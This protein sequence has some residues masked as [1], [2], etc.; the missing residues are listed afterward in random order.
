VYVDPAVAAEALLTNHAEVDS[1]TP[2]SNPDNDEDTAQI[3]IAREADVSIEKSHNEVTPVD[4]YEVGDLVEFTIVV[5]NDAG[6]PSNASGI[7]VTDTLPVGLE[8]VSIA[9]D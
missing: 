1:P 2:D 4:E 7:V 9:G 5:R 6:G 8:F 3:R